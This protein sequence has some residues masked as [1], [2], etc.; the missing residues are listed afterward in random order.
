LIVAGDFNTSSWNPA[1]KRLV[2]DTGLRDSR[3]GFGMQN[4]WN[5]DFLFLRTTIDHCLVSP[6]VKVLN[7][8]VGP[9]IGSD[10]FPILLDL[11]VE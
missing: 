8:R 1:F 10:H 9:D 7:R 5:A 4:S 3:R 2:E 6:K 11:R